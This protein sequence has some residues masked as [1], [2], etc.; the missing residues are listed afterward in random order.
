MKRRLSFA[1]LSEICS[2]FEVVHCMYIWIRVSLPFL[3]VVRYHTN[4]HLVF[5]ASNRV[6]TLSFDLMILDFKLSVWFLTKLKCTP[7]VS[8]LPNAYWPKHVTKWRLESNKPSS[9]THKKERE[10]LLWWPN[11]HYIGLTVRLVYLFSLSKSPAHHCLL[12]KF[13][14]WVT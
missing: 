8:S 10:K 14:S 3:F 2:D 5:H 9:H 11:I 13:S 12:L 6:D 7:S 1:D 4:L